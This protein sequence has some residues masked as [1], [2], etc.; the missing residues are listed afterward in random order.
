MKKCITS[1][2][3]FLLLFTMS[4]AP[5]KAAET[6][7]PVMPTTAPVEEP[8]LMFLFNN[9][10]WIQG[11]AWSPNS[12]EMDTVNPKYASYIDNAEYMGKSNF[13]NFLE[14]HHGDWTCTDNFICTKYDNVDSL[15]ET[16]TLNLNTN[17]IIWEQ[18]VNLDMQMV[19]YFLDI[20]TG[21]SVAVNESQ[22]LYCVSDWQRGK[23]EMTCYDADEADPEYRDVREVTINS[24]NQVVDG[25][26]PFLKHAADDFYRSIRPQH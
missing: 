16:Y 21:R 19:R 14:V 23:G 11:A 4:A 8:D 2:F 5:T 10:A 15:K 20:N 13:K 17:T 1:A 3:A 7:E 25:I 6:S 18:P 9:I 26:Y 22:N 24:V 12:L